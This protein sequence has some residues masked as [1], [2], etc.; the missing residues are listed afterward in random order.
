LFLC[1]QKAY[2]VQALQKVYKAANS[3]RK[4]DIYW[5]EISQLRG[6][7]YIVQRKRNRKLAQ[8]LLYLLCAFIFLF[9][10]II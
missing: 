9:L 10:I 3:L 1:A 8:T 7:L 4:G 6:R 2:D 5:N